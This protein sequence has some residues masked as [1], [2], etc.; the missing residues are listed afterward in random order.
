M[1]IERLTEYGNELVAAGF[2]VYLT[3]TG[4]R[5][6]GYLQYRDPATGNWG[7]LQYSLSASYW[8]H[9]MPMVPSQQFGSSMFVQARPRTGAGSW[10]A[11]A[12][13]LSPWTIE[14][15]RQC[16]SDTNWNEIV[17]TQPNAKDKTWVSARA[18]PLHG[19]PAVEQGHE[20]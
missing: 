20:A 8:Q 14:A 16:A 1:S 9:L 3:K 2:E 4:Y 18:I 7:S 10:N 11:K 6:G 5:E 13:T 15:A 19:I 12:T 17:G